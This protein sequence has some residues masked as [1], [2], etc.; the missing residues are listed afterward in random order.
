MGVRETVYT[1][2][3]GA[4]AGSLV[5]TRCYPDMLPEN[6]TMPAIRYRIISYNDESY[7]EHRNATERAKQRVQLDCYATTSDGAS[8]LADAVRTDFDGWTNGTAVGW[9]R[10]VM[11]I[12]DGW[13]DDIN[14]YR[15]IVDVM[16]DH[17]H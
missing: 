3:T 13:N 1:R 4:S 12:D 7:R 9:A 17:K 16:L 11:R 15:W 8:D 5:S 10:C 14:A 2:V 6:V